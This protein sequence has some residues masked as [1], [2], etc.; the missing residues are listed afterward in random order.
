MP[1]TIPNTLGV[2]PFNPHGNT[3]IGTALITLYL[4]G[5]TE[6]LRGQESSPRPHS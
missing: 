5:E 4:D 2:S 1:G 6:A 3:G